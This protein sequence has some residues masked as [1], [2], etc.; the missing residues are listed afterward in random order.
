[1]PLPWRHLE[2]DPSGEALSFFYGTDCHVV[3]RAKE[4][5]VLRPH[6]HL[7]RS[8]RHITPDETSLTSTAWMSGVFHSMLT[9]GHVSIN[10]M[11][12]T[13]HSYLGL[14]RSHGQ[15]IFVEL[16]G[17]WRLLETPSAFAMSP[18]ACTRIYRYDRGEIQVRSEAGSVAH[19][20][21]LV[22]RVTAGPPLRFLISHHLALNGD[23]GSAPGAAL[24][25]QEAQAIILTPAAGSELAQRFPAGSFSLGALPGTTFEKV[26]GDELLFLDGRSRQ[27]PFLCLVTAATAMVGLRIEGNLLG[28]GTPPPQILNDGSDLEPHLGM[29][30]PERSALRAGATRL[31]DMVPWFAHNAWVHYLAPRGL[32]QYSGGGWGTRDVC[33]GPVEL[34]LALEQVAP[35]RDLLLRVFKQQNPDGDWP[36]WFM[37]FERERNIRPGDSHGDIVFWPLLVLAQYLITSGDR[38]ILEEQVRFFDAGGLDQGENTTLWQHV[39]RALDLTQKRV[40]PGTALAAYGHGDWNDSLQPAEENMRHQLCSSWTVTLQYQTLGN[41]GGGAARHRLPRFSHGIG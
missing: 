38:G 23:D 31:A 17:A 24:W 27:Q 30:I 2:V 20:M 26:G 33:Q 39:L 13:V 12:S 19:D 7:L 1:M 32:E 28:S 3:L 25:R 21:T 34:L 6:G 8:G 14:F 16:D 9:Q 41:S 11:L 37:F 22:L 36:Q 29:S 10:R 5:R 15:R 35:I 40:I 4:L 18:S